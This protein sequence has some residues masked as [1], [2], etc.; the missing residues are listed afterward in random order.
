[1]TASGFGD[2]EPDK[3]T[4]EPREIEFGDADK[5][6]LVGGLVNVVTVVDV[7][8]LVDV[9]VHAVIV[10]VVTVVDVLVELVVVEN[11]AVPVVVAVIVVVVAVVDVTGT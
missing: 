8:V 7:E 3:V 6:M 11:V 1:M 4:E 2:I 9:W 10:V 5:V